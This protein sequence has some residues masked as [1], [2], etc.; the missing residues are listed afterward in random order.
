MKLEVSRLIFKKK[1][2][3]MSSFI[4]ILSVEDERFPLVGSGKEPK[5]EGGSNCKRTAR[6]GRDKQGVNSS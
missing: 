5:R 3:P 1:E 2:A 4:K 6:V